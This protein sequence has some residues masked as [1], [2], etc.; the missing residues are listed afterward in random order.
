M[1]IIKLVCVKEYISPIG[2]N[3][4]LGKVYYGWYVDGLIDSI[5]VNFGNAIGNMSVDHFQDWDKWVIEKRDNIL[6]CIGV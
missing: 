5:I 4:E 1:V 2:L 6:K 3:L